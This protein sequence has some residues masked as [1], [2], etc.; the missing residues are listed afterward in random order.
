MKYLYRFTISLAA[1]S[2]A[3]S[4]QAADGYEVWASDQSNSVSG[5]SG[6]GTKGSYIW[7]WDSADIEAQLAGKGDAQP[8]G[9]GKNNKG[10]AK[11]SKVK[12]GKAKSNVGPC[13]LLDVFPQDLVEYDAKGKKTNNKLSDLNGF[14]RLHGMLPDPQNRYVTANIF[15]PSGGYV[16]II[17]TETK[18]AV[19]LF[20]VTGTNVGGGVD[21]R[22]VHMSFFNSDGSAV[23]IA[24]LNG[25]ILERIETLAI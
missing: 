10:K 19:A 17:D 25:K 20:R 22:T 9:C 5:A 4:A 15:A 14:G 23:L 12:K 24:N 3:L 7:I 1:F 18:G 16:G 13:D 11:K 8:I 6:P 21:V 2:F